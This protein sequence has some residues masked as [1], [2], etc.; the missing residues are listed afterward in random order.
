M[1]FMSFVCDQ[2]DLPVDRRNL[3][4][5]IGSAFAADS[6]IMTN[7]QV[8]RVNARLLKKIPAGAGLGGGS[9]DGARTLLGLDRLW[10]THRAADYLSGF[11]ARFGS[12]LPFFFFGP[13]SVCQGRG[14]IVRPIAP[15]RPK[16]ALLMLPPIHM[17]TA[18]VYRRF[19]A[20]H[21]GRDEDIEREPDWSTWVRS[22]A[23]LLLDRLINDLE[24]PAFAIS[25][26]LADLRKEMERN[27]SRPVRMSGSGSGLF[28]LYDSQARGGFRAQ[29]DHATTIER[30][31]YRTGCGWKL[32]RPSQDFVIDDLTTEIDDGGSVDEQLDTSGWGKSA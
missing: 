1:G 3:V 28:T 14:E 15:P 2:T 9:S 4:V 12:D 30:M 10:S 17:P 22:D 7:A 25:P 31:D 20:M 16:W 13:S 6:L 27:L 11:A 8:S 23:R 29:A 21:L 26:A 18:E 32:S 19:D 24:P 5:K